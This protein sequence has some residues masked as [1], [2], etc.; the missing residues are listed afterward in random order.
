MSNFSKLKLLGAPFG[1]F[2]E[3]RDKIA[4]S[5]AFD[6]L[7]LDGLARNVERDS[8]VEFLVEN[9]VRRS[10]YNYAYRRMIMDVETA[11]KRVLS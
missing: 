7:Y 8:R 1:A 11:R 2:R 6:E 3:W 10:M 9:S 5:A 4:P